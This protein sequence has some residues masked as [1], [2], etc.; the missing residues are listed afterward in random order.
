MLIPLLLICSA[1]C[2]SRLLLCCSCLNLAPCTPGAFHASLLYRN[3]PISRFSGLAVI[4]FIFNFRLCFPASGSS[5]CAPQ[6]HPTDFPLLQVYFATNSLTYNIVSRIFNVAQSSYAF[7]NIIARIPE[8][9][10]GERVLIP[11]LLIFYDS[12]SSITILSIL[13][14][15]FLT[16]HI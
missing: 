6:Y 10:F 14:Q 4:L 11:C 12:L 9:Y 15:S 3:C 8:E 1:F 5:Y 13:N 2:I 16:L 7:S